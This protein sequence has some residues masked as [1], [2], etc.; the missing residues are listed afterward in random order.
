M[1]DAHLPDFQAQCVEPLAARACPVMAAAG[2]LS[3]E[4]PEGSAQG[5]MAWE[6]PGGGL[7]LIDAYQT[8]T[9]RLILPA[10]EIPG[11]VESVPGVRV[12]VEETDDGRVVLRADAEP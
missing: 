12:S 11:P 4:P 8:G 10:G 1:E 5:F 6:A 3:V 9:C 7:L 2:L